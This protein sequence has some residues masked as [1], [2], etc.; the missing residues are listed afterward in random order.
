MATGLC[1]RGQVFASHK[2]QNL[3]QCPLALGL[4]AHLPS[5]SASTG[6]LA[7]PSTSTLDPKERVYCNT[8][9][10]LVLDGC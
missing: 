9:S 6:C 7:R 8:P 3:Q 5:A 10:F 2:E 1:Q 4:D